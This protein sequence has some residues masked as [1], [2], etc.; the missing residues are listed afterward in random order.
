MYGGTVNVLQLERPDVR[1]VDIVTDPTARLAALAS[2]DRDVRARVVLEDPDAPIPR[3]VDRADATVKVT[4][5]D[6]ERVELLV[7]TSHDGYVRLADPHDAGW[8]VTV[9]GADAP[10]YVADHYLR[11]VYVEAGEHRLVFTY[12]GARAVWPL[13]LSLVALLAVLATLWAGRRS[14]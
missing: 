2:R 9:D 13:R 8:R 7:Q 14:R 3:P 4:L 11:A 10:L 1:G 6:D 12:D 5:H